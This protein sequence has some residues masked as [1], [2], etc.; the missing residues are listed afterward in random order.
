MLFRSRA[1]DE[2]RTR[3]PH[4]GKVRMTVR[5]VRLVPCSIPQSPKPS[6]QSVQS[7][8]FVY[9]STITRALCEISGSC[10]LPGARH[11]HRRDAVDWG[12]RPKARSLA[13]AAAEGSRQVSAKLASEIAPW[14]DCITDLS[15]NSTAFHPSFRGT[16][17]SIN[18]RRLV[19]DG[20]MEPAWSGLPS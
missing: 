14:F 17:A 15:G 19:G 18:P 8:Q 7:V 2:I 13:V 3:D 10:R 16:K 11:S 12:R 6:V 5:T 9:R 1:D 20:V 4:L